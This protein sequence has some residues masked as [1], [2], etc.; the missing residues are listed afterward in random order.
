MLDY[1][2]LTIVK[3]QVFIGI[4]PMEHFK[5]NIVYVNSMLLL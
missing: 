1:L 3:A 5:N 4:I 2:C